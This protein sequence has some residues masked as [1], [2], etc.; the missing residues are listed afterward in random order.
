MKS[1]KLPPPSPLS[2]ST[3]RL[4]FRL[5]GT[6]RVDRQ[7]YPKVVFTFLLLLVASPF[8]WIDRLFFARRI[9]QY[10]FEESPLF[11]LGHWRSGTTLLHN[12]LTLDPA[13]G[14]VTTYHA[15]FP[16]NLKS[17]WLFGTFMRIFMPRHRPGDQLELAVHLPQED[18]YALSNLTF[19]RTITSFIFRRPMKSCIKVASGSNR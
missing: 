2:G 16:N 11:I 19:F 4:F 6:C 12:L 1:F 8:Q 17:A 18:E 7:H 3:L 5:L 15:V 10:R 14:Y 9:D 13:A